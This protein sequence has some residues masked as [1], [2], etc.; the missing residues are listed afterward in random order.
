MFRTLLITLAL[1]FF[2][3][4]ASA[5]SYTLKKVCNGKTCY[6]VKV[7]INN[8]APQTRTY[9]APVA[10][11][12]QGY[13]LKKVCNNGVCYYVRVPIQSTTVSDQV[14]QQTTRNRPILGGTVVRNNV[15]GS[16]PGVT[17]TVVSSVPTVSASKTVKV[18]EVPELDLLNL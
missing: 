7:P 16:L 11:T 13:T 5:Q 15:I 8:Y 2:A 10:Q 3:T 14:V 4:V 12:T 9:V 18:A 6:Y 1:S 17:T